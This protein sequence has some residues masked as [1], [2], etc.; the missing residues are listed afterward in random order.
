MEWG[1]R[2]QSGR[3]F[4]RR[5]SSR[6]VAVSVVEDGG[7]GEENDTEQ[8]ISTSCNDN[9]D[10]EETIQLPQSTHCLLFT[11]NICSLPFAVALAVAF[12]SMSCLILALFD[13]IT[14]FDNEFQSIPANIPPE[15]RAAQYFSI[16]IALAM[17]E[18][19]P[20]A[21][22]LLRMID[23]SAVEGKL[24]GSYSRFVL[25]CLCRLLIGAAFLLNVFLVLAQ[26]KFG[27][28]LCIYFSYITYMIIIQY[29]AFSV[30]LCI[31]IMLIV[32]CIYICISYITYMLIIHDALIEL[33][34]C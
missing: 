26:S 15:V 32:L 31:Y 12:I 34:K 14:L 5:S 21:L 6:S 4:H 8:I 16:L 20:T 29:I 2:R 24:K 23:R 1:Q 30:I 9:D 19:I 25:S 10:H 33:S 13:N 28:Y 27:E 7:G 22:Y 18:E 17:E 3:I 11:E